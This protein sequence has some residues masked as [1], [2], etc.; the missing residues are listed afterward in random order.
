[1]SDV[2]LQIKEQNIQDCEAEI[3]LLHAEFKVANEAVA[4]VRNPY[5]FRPHHLLLNKIYQGISIVWYFVGCTGTVDQLTIFHDRL[6]M[7]VYHGDSGLNSQG[8]PS[9]WTHMVS[10]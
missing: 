8:Q 10:L 2:Q 6:L 3:A 4:K 9:S 5:L 7:L 1:M